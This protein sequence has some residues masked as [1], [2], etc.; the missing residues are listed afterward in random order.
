M[1]PSYV[2]IGARVRRGSM[3]DTWATVG[4]APRSV[5][6]HLSGVGIGGVLEPP[7]APVIVGDECLIGSRCVVADGTR[8]D[9]GGARRC[10]LGVHPGDRVVERQ[11]GRAWCRACLDRRGR[12]S[13]ADVARRTR[14]QAAVRAAH[15]AVGRG[16]RHDKSTLND[17]LRDHGA[18]L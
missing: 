16:R 5:A 9:D 6:T 18:T 10:V 14:V 3:V 12:H 8:A 4:A 13:V 11:R 2:N 7:S 15:Q 17:V 1:M